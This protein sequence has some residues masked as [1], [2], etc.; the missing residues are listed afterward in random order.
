MGGNITGSTQGT[1]TGNNSGVYPDLV[2]ERYDGMGLQYGTNSFDTIVLKVTGLDVAKKYN[3]LASLVITS[4]VC[5]FCSRFAIGS[6]T[7]SVRYF[8]NTTM[9]DTLENVVPNAA[10]EVIIKCI[11]DPATNRGGVLNAMVIKAKYDDRLGSC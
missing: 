3:L 5:H 11:G 10:G 1:I 8:L 2:D 4:M 7:A 6:D 9:T